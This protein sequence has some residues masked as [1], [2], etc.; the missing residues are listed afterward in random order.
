MIKENVYEN[1]KRDFQKFYATQDIGNYRNYKDNNLRTI[2]L[3]LLKRI[4]VYNYSKIPDALDTFEY[5]KVENIPNYL[6][7]N[8]IF[9]GIEYEFSFSGS[10]GHVTLR[11]IEEEEDIYHDKQSKAHQYYFNIQMFSNRG[12]VKAKKFKT[13]DLVI[14][15]TEDTNTLYRV[16][17]FNY[18]YSRT[19]YFICDCRNTL[20]DKEPRTIWRNCVTIYE[21]RLKGLPNGL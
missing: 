5:T 14:I 16:E 6:E 9:N 10:L 18:R 19:Q 12:L 13:G 15:K 7:G 3:D 8:F 2:A 11:V 20:L 17:H 4:I 1:L 21:S